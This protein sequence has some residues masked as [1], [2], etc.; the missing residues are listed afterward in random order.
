M[1]VG[2]IGK[3]VAAR[4]DRAAGIEIEVFEPE[5]GRR[6]GVAFEIRLEKFPGLI[7]AAYVEVVSLTGG[8]LRVN[9]LQRA[10]RR[11]EMKQEGH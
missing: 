7:D 6:R 8:R 9:D 4:R 2:L 5:I 1:R 3:A 11:H 10:N